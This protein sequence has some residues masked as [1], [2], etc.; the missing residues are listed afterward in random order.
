MRTI[1]ISGTAQTKPYRI[2]NC[3][4]G[5]KVQYNVWIWA[6]RENEPIQL[7]KTLDVLLCGH[8]DLWTI[9]KA[10]AHGYF[11]DE[12]FEDG[13]YTTYL[14]HLIPYT[15]NGYLKQETFSDG[16]PKPQAYLYS[17][18]NN[19]PVTLAEILTDLEFTATADEV[20]ALLKMPVNTIISI[21]GLSV[22]RL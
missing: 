7:V 8:G 13:A 9:A 12:K 3:S 18:E 19:T 17:V 11:N 22:I 4:T 20:N 15:M 6:A 2:S 10:I 21:R 1:L 5:F 14:D 16:T